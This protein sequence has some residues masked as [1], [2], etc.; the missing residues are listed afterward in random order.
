ML[1]AIRAFFSDSMQPP[2][3]DA[4]ETPRGDEVRLAACALMLEIAWADDDFT[5]AEREHLASAVRRHWALDASRA[6]EVIRMAEEERKRA[7]DLYQFTRLIRER[8]S[9]GQ[10]MV[11]AE[12]LWGLVYAD[13]ELSSHEDHLVRKI[14]NLLDLEVAWL[15]EARNRAR[16]EADDVGRSRFGGEGTAPPDHSRVD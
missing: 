2:E 12:V 14:S 13:G 10:K 16:R 1:D 4:T 8:Y 11:L 3:D 9:L 5:E 15:S 7:A 6:E